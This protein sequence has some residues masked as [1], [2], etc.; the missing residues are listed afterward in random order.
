MLHLYDRATMAHALTLD[1]EP[2][3]HALLAERIGSLVTANYDLTDETELLI[4]DD[5]D[6]EEDIVHHF[7]FSPLIEPINGIR[8]GSEGFQPFWDYLIHHGEWYEMGVSFGS[9]FAYLLL[10]S[11]RGGAQSCLRR[12]C[13]E[14]AR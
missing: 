1:L 4:V 12:L 3:L 13:R 8:F 9:T 14:Y 2:S 5:R 10:I 6:T 7:G 11:N